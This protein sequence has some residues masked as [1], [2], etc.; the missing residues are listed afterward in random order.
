MNGF[1]SYRRMVYIHRLG[2][3]ALMSRGGG[4]WEG[5]PVMFKKNILKK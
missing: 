3:V 5:S 2:N 1:Y 4:F